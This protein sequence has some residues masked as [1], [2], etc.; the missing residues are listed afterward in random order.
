[1]KEIVKSWTLKKHKIT[2]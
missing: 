1:M 2:T